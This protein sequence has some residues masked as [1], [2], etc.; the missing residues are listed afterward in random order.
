MI[1]K[2]RNSKG[3]VMAEV[4]FVYPI[5]LF[6]LFSFVEF[7]RALYVQS[8]LA[9]AAQ[10]VAGQIAM[11]ARR[12][13]FYNISSFSSFADRVRYPGSVVNSKQFSFDVVDLQNNSTVDPNGLADGVASTKVIVTVTFPPQNRPDLRIPIF[14]PGRLIGQPVFGKKGLRLRSQ[15]VRFLERSRRPTV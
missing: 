9:A 14:D 15:A 5:F 3:S 8:T 4:A 12:T 6:L 11:K 10:Q 2:K 7:S 1:T 13:P